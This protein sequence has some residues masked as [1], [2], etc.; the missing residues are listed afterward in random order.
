MKMKERIIPEY[1]KSVF[2]R[3]YLLLDTVFGEYM[4]EDERIRAFDDYATVFGIDEMDWLNKTHGAISSRLVSSARTLPEYNMLARAVEFFPSRFDDDTVRVIRH[5]QDAVQTKHELFATGSE[6]NLEGTLARL[7]S[8]ANSGDADCMALMAYLELCGILIPENKRGALARIRDAARCNHLFALLMGLSR[9]EETEEYAS[10]LRAV[11]EGSS[12]TASYKYLETLYTLPTVE[13]SGVAR[14]LEKRYDLGISKRGKLNEDILKVLRS[15]VLTEESKIKL[16]SLGEKEINLEAFPLDID[17][18]Q[19]AR[20]PTRLSLAGLIDRRAEK[21]AILATLSLY[22]RRDVVRYR[23]LLL[24][25]A[26]DYVLSAYKASLVKAFSGSSVVTV[27]MAS[28]SGFPCLPTKENPIINELNRSGNSGTVVILENCEELDARQ[29]DELGKF[30][31]INCTRR[32]L[33]SV[34]SLSFDFTDIFPILLSH[35]DLPDDVRAECDEIRLAPVRKEEKLA[36]IKDILDQRCATFE[37][38]RITL[39][40]AAEERLSK[41]PLTSVA[42]VIDKV[43]ASSAIDTREVAVKDEDI[44]PYIPKSTGFEPKS[45]WG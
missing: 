6:G 38:E 15:A 12:Q 23:P 13:P 10:I 29:A 5:K 17:R 27:D 43:L 26:D 40:A 22:N 2:V 19:T 28:C 16:L 7:E 1:L 8:R 31:R 34:N 3:Q 4:S 21:R 25:S 45:F 35:R 42:T 11:L 24:T 32:S 44:K 39:D 36:A 20:V 9:G 14:A 33:M 30:L 37:L 41:L 18:C